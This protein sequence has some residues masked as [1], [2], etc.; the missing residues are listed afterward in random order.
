MLFS[1]RFLSL[2]NEKTVELI[3]EHKN[4]LPCVDITAAEWNFNSVRK[5]ALQASVQNSL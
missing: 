5:P 2:K 3:R 4:V 1:F